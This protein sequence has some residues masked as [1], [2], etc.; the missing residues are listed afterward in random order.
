MRIRII[1][2]GEEIAKEAADLITLQI[3][4]K[5]DSVLG[6]ATGETPLRLYQELIKRVESGRISFRNVVTFNLDEYVGLSPSHPQSYNSYMKN[7]I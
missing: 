5:P 1:E 3:K 6:L 4:A 2:N 7:H